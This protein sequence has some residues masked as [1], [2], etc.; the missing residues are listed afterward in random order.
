M[1]GSLGCSIPTLIRGRAAGFAVRSTVKERIFASSSKDSGL[2]QLRGWNPTLLICRLP[3]ELV[4]FLV[5]RAQICLGK[6]PAQGC[7]RAEPTCCVQG[8]GKFSTV[9]SLFPLVNISHAASAAGW[10]G[11][12]AS[13]LLLLLVGIFFTAG[14]E[15]CSLLERGNGF[16]RRC[17]LSCLLGGDREQEGWTSHSLRALGAAAP[18]FILQAAGS[19]GVGDAPKKCAGLDLP[20]SPR[21]SCAAPS[22]SCLPAWV[23]WSSLCPPQSS[24]LCRDP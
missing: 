6:S 5:P 3:W 24:E 7:S 4:I 20:F 19:C 15:V 11:W 1:V 12:E 22:H 10:W 9:G 17:W 8:E 16:V 2:C 21:K 18:L 13:S 23:L 14:F